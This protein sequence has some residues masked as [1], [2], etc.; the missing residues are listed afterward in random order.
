MPQFKMAAPGDI[1]GCEDCDPPRQIQHDAEIAAII[2]VD[3]NAAD[4]GNQQAGR[5]GHDHLIAD[6]DGGMR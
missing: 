2:P 5:G 1:R 3:Q 6:L 4:E